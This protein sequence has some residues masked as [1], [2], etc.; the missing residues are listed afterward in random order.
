MHTTNLSEIEKRPKQNTNVPGRSSYNFSI[1]L[2]VMLRQNGTDTELHWKQPDIIIIII[3]IKFFQLYHQYKTIILSYSNK[4]LRKH[5]YILLAF[6]CLPNNH[7]S[8]VIL[9]KR[10]DEKMHDNPY[11]CCQQILILERSHILW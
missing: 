5:P 8:F 9:E 2:L 7:A 4:K 3:I 6:A 10:T 11:N 1:V